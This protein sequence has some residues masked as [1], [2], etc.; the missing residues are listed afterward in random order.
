MRDLR[1]PNFSK[2]SHRI[3]FSFRESHRMRIKWNCILFIPTKPS[4]STMNFP[5]QLSERMSLSRIVFPVVKGNLN[6]L[7]IA[8]LK[9][10]SRPNSMCHQFVPLTYFRKPMRVLS[11]RPQSGQKPNLLI[12]VL[13]NQHSDRDPLLTK[14]QSL[15]LMKK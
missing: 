14:S 1:F 15:I 12:K 9:W 6:L 13:F 4:P 5:Y 11:S 3:D 7:I 8:L 2:Q 10:K